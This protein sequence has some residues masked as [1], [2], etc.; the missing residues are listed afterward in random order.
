[1]SCMVTFSTDLWPPA[2]EQTEVGFSDLIGPMPRDQGDPNSQHRMCSSPRGYLTSQMSSLWSVAIISSP[3]RSR[4]IHRAVG[5]NAIAQ[6]L[7]H[8][9]L[10]S[11]TQ[12]ATIFSQ[13]NFYFLPP[14]R[15]LVNE[16]SPVFY[17]TSESTLVISPREMSASDFIMASTYVN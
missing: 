10:S 17:L 8:H 12:K 16:K 1:M 7:V 5:N 3:H 2:P 6:C 14:P 15:N 11:L 4:E 9:K 13:W